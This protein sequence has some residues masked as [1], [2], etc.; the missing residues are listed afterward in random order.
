MAE[1][2]VAGVTHDE[3]KKALK[4]MKRGKALGSDNIPMEAWISLEEAGVG[5]DI[6]IQQIPCRRENVRGLEKEHIDTHLQEQ[7]R[8]AGLCTKRGT[9]ALHA[10]VI[11]TGSVCKRGTYNKCMAAVRSTVGTTEGFKVEVELHQGSALSPFF[12]AAIMDKL[13]NGPRKGAPWSMMFADERREVEEDLER[14]RHDWRAV[15]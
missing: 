8:R 5:N 3:V 15:A 2:M 11:D 4:K 9:V 6:A 13:T 12:F 14:E 7:S 1:V 10:R